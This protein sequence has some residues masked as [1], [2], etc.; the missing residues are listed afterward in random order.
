MVDG[1]SRTRDEDEDEDDVSDKDLPDSNR[2]VR[3]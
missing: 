2:A 3:P 1:K